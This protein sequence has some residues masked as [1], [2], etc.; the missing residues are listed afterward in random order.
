MEKSAGRV[1]SPF[2][3]EILQELDRIPKFRAQMNLL[4]TE[5]RRHKS[6]QSGPKLTW[7]ECLHLLQ[8]FLWEKK[9]KKERK[10]TWRAL[11]AK[12]QGMA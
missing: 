12:S 10:E 3:R 6:R 1:C 5:Q 11:W 4:V 8:Q 2:P 9:K 7:A